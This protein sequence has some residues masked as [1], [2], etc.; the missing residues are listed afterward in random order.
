MKALVGAFNQERALVGAFSI[1]VKTGCGTDR[2]LH[3]TILHLLMLQAGGAGG[4][5]AEEEA[6]AQQAA[7]VAAPRPGEHHH[8]AHS[9]PGGRHQTSQYRYV[10]LV[11]AIVISS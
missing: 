3:S 8:R 6:E 2:A 11:T 5:A 7:P 1:N 9:H 4:G 10:F